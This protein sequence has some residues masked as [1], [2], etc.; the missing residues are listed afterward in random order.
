M[1][2]KQAFLDLLSEEYQQYL[3]IPSTQWQK[4]RENKQFI[5]GLMTASRLF[6]ISFDEL[7]E[8]VGC[9]SNQALSIED[10]LE[11]PTYIRENIEIE[12]L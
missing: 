6:G 10:M 11:V 12:S 1:N 5:R 4:K 3:A 2:N 7:S 8:I 9:D